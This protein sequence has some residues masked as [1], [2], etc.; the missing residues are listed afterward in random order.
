MD[1]I[2][3]PEFRICI[4]N[5]PGGVIWAEG[6]LLKAYQWTIE[7]LEVTQGSLNLNFLNVTN[8]IFN[9]LSAT[10]P[11]LATLRRDLGGFKHLLQILTRQAFRNVNNQTTLNTQLSMHLTDAAT[12]I[13]L[14]RHVWWDNHAAPEGATPLTHI[15]EFLRHLLHHVRHQEWKCHAGIVLEYRFTAYKSLV[16]QLEDAFHQYDDGVIELDEMK[17][18]HVAC[19]EARR[20]TMLAFDDYI[21]RPNGPPFGLPAYWQD[22]EGFLASNFRR[23]FPNFIVNNVLT[24]NDITTAMINRDLHDLMVMPMPA[25]FND[26]PEGEGVNKLLFESLARVRSYK[27]DSKLLWPNKPRA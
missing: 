18:M 23:I 6:E 8:D 5:P 9:T 25:T 14:T 24:C 3:T 17:N 21:G 1:A 4:A 2:Y 7:R 11:A 13:A 15:T 22:G 12:V 26:W 10:V 20:I 27:E 16:A 19:K